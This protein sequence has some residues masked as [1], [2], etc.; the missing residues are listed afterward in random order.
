[1]QNLYIITLATSKNNAVKNFELSCK[2]NNL[3]Y[4]IIGLNENFLG[5]RW[6]MEKYYNE[7]KNYKNND[8]IIFCDS[9]DILFQESQNEILKKF[10]SLNKP[11]VISSEMNLLLPPQLDQFDFNPLEFTPNKFKISN[12]SD[13]L[14][15]CMG[16]VIGYKKD[17]QKFYRL[18]LSY[19][20][21][22]LKE[23]CFHDDQCLVSYYFTKNHDKIFT[24]DYDQ[25][26]FGNLSGSLNRY[27]FIENK[28][29]NK[30]TNNTPSLLHFQ[31]NSL[32]YYNEYMIP[33]GYKEV[34][35]KVEIVPFNKSKVV[36]TYFDKYHEFCW[37]N[38]FQTYNNMN[39]SDLFFYR[40]IYKLI[41]IMIIFLIIYSYTKLNI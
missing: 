7:L 19:N 2:K 38:I 26:I 41:I 15:P 36:K 9:Y 24:L 4:K 14:Y 34:D 1:M 16:G 18:L 32:S 28:L 35:T 3:K 30:K 40:S 17:L 12:N 33:L 39:N 13:Y 10:K 8:V 27:E 37:Q 6:R 5:W 20:D 22:N 25:K 29:F 11:I 31:G 21:K 23:S